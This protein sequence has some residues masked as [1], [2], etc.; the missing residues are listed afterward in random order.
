VFD[1]IKRIH[2]T[3]AAHCA[4][5][6]AWSRSSEEIS[7][8]HQR[9]RA[10]SGFAAA[11]AGAELMVQEVK[12]TLCIY[13]ALWGGKFACETAEELLLQ[14]V[15]MIERTAGKQRVRETLRSVSKELKEE[16]KRR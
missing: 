8:G 5:H 13:E 3:H 6:A 7:N 12:N 2:L 10:D 15:V 9:R 16:A 4:R 1:F 11:N 14:A